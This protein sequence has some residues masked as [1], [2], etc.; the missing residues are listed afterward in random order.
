V[1]GESH[2]QDDLQRLFRKNGGTEHDIKVDAVLVPED[3]N[4]FDAH[5]VRVE[6]GSRTVGYLVRR[7]AMI[8]VNVGPRTL[9]GG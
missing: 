5:A 3:G 7:A 1:V 4:D 6:I 2:Y 8:P 9:D